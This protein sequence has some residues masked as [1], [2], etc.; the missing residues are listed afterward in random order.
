MKKTTKTLL[1]I[2]CLFGTISVSFS[3]YTA[4]ERAAYEY[5][6][7]NNITTQPTIETADME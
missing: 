5:A 1:L 4:E 2:L 3:G 7:K 6:Y